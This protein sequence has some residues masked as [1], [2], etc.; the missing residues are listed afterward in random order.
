MECKIQIR[1]NITEVIKLI[2][3]KSASNYEE[4]NKILNEIIQDFNLM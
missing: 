1:I 2:T 4:L 3:K